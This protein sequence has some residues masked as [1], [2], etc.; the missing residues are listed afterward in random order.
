MLISLAMGYRCAPYYF[1]DPNL[2]QKNSVQLL[3]FNN[4][5]TNKLRINELLT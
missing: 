3:Q 1:R 2:A 5:L 4:I